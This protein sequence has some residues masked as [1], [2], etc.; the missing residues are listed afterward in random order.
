MYPPTTLVC[1]AKKIVDFGCFAAYI[2]GKS[3]RYNLKAGN[4]AIIKKEYDLIAF[5]NVRINKM[6]KNYEERLDYFHNKFKLYT[7][8]LNAIYDFTNAVISNLAA[9]NIKIDSNINNINF[10]LSKYIL[11]CIDLSVFT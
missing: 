8:D 4:V 6:P 2:I 1:E 3:G 5:Y 11:K 7:N 10:A 9:N